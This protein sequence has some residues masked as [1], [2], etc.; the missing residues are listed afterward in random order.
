MF[1]TLYCIIMKR[2]SLKLVLFCVF[3]ICFLSCDKTETYTIMVRSDNSIMGTTSGSGK[4]AANTEVVIKAF[5]NSGYEFDKW[6]DGN[7]DNPRTIIVSSDY[8]FVAYFKVK[9]QGGED[10]DDDDEDDSGDEDN[11]DTHDTGQVID[12]EGNVYS[13]VKI[14]NTWWMSENMKAISTKNGTVI[15]TIPAQGHSSNEDPMCYCYGDSYSTAGA[16]GRLY[17]WPAAQAVCPEGWHL[18]TTQEWRNMIQEVGSHPENV[19]GGNVENVSKAL[20]STSGWLQSSV[21]G[22]PG[23]SPS[24]NNR[25]GF[26]CYAA[27]KFESDQFSA[28]TADACLWTATD[29]HEQ[30]YS[31][32]MSYDKTYMELGLKNKNNGHSVRCVKND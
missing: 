18:P 20:A 31:Y 28:Q 17:N 19:F 6:Q 4:Y 3:A 26:S 15:L 16:E 25:V 8:E 14:G 21:A 9:G 12:H 22:T 27:G 11:D 13:T 7:T 30:A 23:N 1:N 32:T 29:F 24:T 10:D 5:P 2:R